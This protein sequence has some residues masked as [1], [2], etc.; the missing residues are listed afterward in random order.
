M[1]SFR[2]NAAYMSQPFFFFGGGER[3]GVRKNFKTFFRKSEVNFRTFLRIV[4]DFRI[5]LRISEA[6]FKMV[7]ERV[8]NTLAKTNCRNI[9]LE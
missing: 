1:N 9:W 2:K 6:A 5:F 8:I 3:G 7:A 4:N